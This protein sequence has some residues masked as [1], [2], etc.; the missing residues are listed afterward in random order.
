MG[1]DAADCEPR[2]LLSPDSICPSEGHNRVVMKTR[3]TYSLH[4]CGSSN[5]DVHKTA[6]VN[7][8]LGTTWARSGQLLVFRVDVVEVSHPLVFR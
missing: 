4:F 1:T 7:T 6:S 5:Q 3:E 8:T 2:S